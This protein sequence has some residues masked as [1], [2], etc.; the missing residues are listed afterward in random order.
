MENDNKPVD[1]LRD[2]RVKASIWEKETDKGP[3]HSVTFART[4][5]DQD[6]NYAD[7]HSFSGTDL[8]KV[9][10]LAE[11]TY[12]QVQERRAQSYAERQRETAQ[13]S[14]KQQE[15]EIER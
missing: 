5:R 7:A 1:T 9:S 11:R 4:Y 3:F 13:G 6:G 12:D 14:G 15:L 10:R 2:G 8:L